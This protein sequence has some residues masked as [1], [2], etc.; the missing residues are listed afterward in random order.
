MAF[1]ASGSYTTTVNSVTTTTKIVAYLIS[2]KNWIT[3]N[4]INN[5]TNI[6]AL[7]CTYPNLYEFSL[8]KL[9]VEC[10]EEIANSI[11]AGTVNYNFNEN[12]FQYDYYQNG[13]NR[14]LTLIYTKD[15]EQIIDPLI[16]GNLIS[17]Q[18]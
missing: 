15:I 10:T 6:N 9:S 3:I 12:D 1:I 18:S 4:T 13:V 16:V 11:S 7:G 2:G 5:L 8:S 14:Q 17:N